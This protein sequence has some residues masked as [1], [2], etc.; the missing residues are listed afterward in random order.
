MRTGHARLKV[1]DLER[2]LRLSCGVPGFEI[3]RRYG[4]PA[5]LVPADTGGGHSPGDPAADE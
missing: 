5:A 1:A 4:P 3:T 2:A